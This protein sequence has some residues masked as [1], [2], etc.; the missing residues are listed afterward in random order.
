[1]KL[2]H[3]GGQ[4]SECQGRHIAPGVMEYYCNEYLEDAT[5]SK[6]IVY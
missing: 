1:M 2:C 3:G 6:W 5:F 4:Y